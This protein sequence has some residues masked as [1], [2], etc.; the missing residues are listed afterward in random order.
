MKRLL[1]TLTSLCMLLICCRPGSAEDLLIDDFEAD[2]YQKWT[3]TGDA[4]GSAPAEGTL[5]G[6]MPVT[7]YRGDR[8]V[9]TFR[10]GDSATGIALSAEFEI[11]RSHIAFL[12]GGGP[13]VETVGM[14]LLL[15]GQPVRSATGFE[16]ESLRWS[17]WDVAELK[18]Q[19]V[20][21]RIF[22]IAT[23]GWG[24]ICVDHILQ[25]DVP[26]Q[27]FDLDAA[28][29]RYRARPDYMNEPYRPQFHF[30]PEINWM[31][32]PNGLV[33]HDG[34]YHLF[35]Q[36]NPEGNVWGHMSWG[37]AVSRDLLHWQH[38]PLAIPEADGVMAF[39]GGC[40]VDHHNTSGF[41]DG[42][43]PPMVAIYTGHGHGEQ[44]QNL[45]YSN[46]NGRTWTRY[47]GNPVLDLDLADFRD[48]KVFWHKPTRR[49]VMVVSLATEKVLVFYGSNNLKSWT[50][51]SR[52]G[53]AGV[54]NKPNWE[55]PDLFELPVDGKPGE[56]HWVLEV[57][58]GAG[59]IAGGS[60]GEYFVG[61]FD[62]ERFRTTQH[63]LWVDFGRDFYAPVSWENIPES[64]GRRLWIG[65]FNNWE[66]SLLPTS[67]W[68]SCM[69]VPRSLSLRHVAFND[70]EPATWVLVQRPVQELRQLRTGSQKLD[71]TSVA[72]PPVPVTQPGDLPDMTFELAATLRPGQARSVGL[73]IRTG[74]EEFT[75]IA[76]DRH[77]AG[78]YVDRTQSGNVG[79]HQ[80]FAGRH[81]APARLIDGDV[82]LQILVDRS[83]IEVFINDGEAVISDRIFPT[84][85]QPVIE[86]FAGDDSASIPSA[87]LHP[88]RSI[89]SRPL[90]TVSES[91]ME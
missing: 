88:L 79:F 8:L 11:K 73:R 42:T 45:A 3:V 63:A 43:T 71:T 86:L 4:F 70:E 57:D 78:V 84:G 82:T 75:E 72:W 46:D 37:H 5:P 52:F 6:Q 12:I 35:H 40:V 30:S 60:G 39:S 55:C 74:E 81:T 27:R 83:T 62:G 33:F 15:E 23:E 68:R 17:S 54:I 2:S 24:H 66:T 89:W 29:A 44:V 49:W 69:S 51:L 32:D 91:L 53:P 61:T 28:L 19:R 1:T 67:P 18:G 77:Y 85:R 59:S 36:Y 47:E 80:A 65:W 25:T 13:H 14:Q 48:P 7:G 64:D 26:P 38:L 21:L 9:N 34:E 50:E 41:G 22:D 20:Q 56:S 87:T 90:E 10:G 76:Y 31:N 16:S 58:M